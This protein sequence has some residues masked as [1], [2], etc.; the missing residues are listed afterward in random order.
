MEQQGKNTYYR[1]E[2]EYQRRKAEIEERR[3]KTL[4]KQA[5]VLAV[6]LL[7]VCLI[8]GDYF[9]DQTRMAHH[10][11]IYGVSVSGMTIENAAQKIENAFEKTGLFF[12]ENGDAIYQTTLGKAGFSLDADALREE[13]G[14][15]QAEML[16]DRGLIETKKNIEIEYT[17]LTDEDQLSQT[18]SADNFEVE[19]ER[20]ES[21]DAYLEYD[22][23]A[24]EFVIVS[25]WQGNAI[26]EDNLREVLDETMEESFQEDGPILESI[27]VRLDVNSYQTVEVTENSEDLTSRME[28]LNQSLENYSNTSVVYTFGS[29]TEE[30]DSDTICSW[31]EIT[32]DGVHLDTSEI[33]TYIDEL[34]ATYNTKYYTRYFTTTAGDM[35]TV[36]NNEYGFLI[37]KDLEYA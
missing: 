30:L 32:D 21:S 16:E 22:S 7:F 11:S 14:R 27:T 5:T 29:V 6:V 15:V 10:L 31:L 33:W 4:R 23:D 24:G 8:L 35:V 36:T 20:T 19:L 28:Q 25:S 26:D 2:R 3:K 18:L 17:V 1:R 9:L 12:T 34:A 37:D 13:L